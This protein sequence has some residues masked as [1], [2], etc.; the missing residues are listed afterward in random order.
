MEGGRG[1]MPKKQLFSENLIVNR[2]FRDINPL[3]CGEEQCEPLHAFGPAVREHYLL[4][5]VFSGKGNF[6]AGGKVLPVS[7]G[8][9]FVIAPFVQTYYQADEKDPWHYGWVGFESGVEL[10]FLFSQYIIDA[11]G[12]RRIFQELCGCERAH[13]AKEFYISSKIFELIALLSE[14]KILPQENSP[15]YILKAVNYIESNYVQPISVNKLAAA[16]NL[17]RS[18]FSIA[19]KRAT[20]KSP[21]QYIVDYRL[22]KAADLMV[23][24]SYRPGEAGQS[25]GYTDIFNFSRMFKRRFG[26]SPTEYIARS[27]TAK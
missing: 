17:D 8:Q 13:I 23:R 3:L 25:V 27:R 14:Q 11:P 9:I 15:P 21:Q 20:G 2:G 5:Y 24:Y 7:T 6:H 19:F 18:Y 4:H 16:L 26:V 22:E 1:R 12:A 10:D